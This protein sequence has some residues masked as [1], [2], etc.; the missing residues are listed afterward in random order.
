MQYVASSQ[1]LS[2]QRGDNCEVRHLRP[3]HARNAS[4]FDPERSRTKPPPSSL[5]GFLPCE[6]LLESEPLL[7][8]RRPLDEF[9]DTPPP[10]SVEVVRRLAERGLS[11]A[12]SIPTPKVSALP[13]SMVAHGQKASA[14]E[15]F[16]GDGTASPSLLLLR[17]TP[18]G[19]AAD[20]LALPVPGEPR[21]LRAP[22]PPDL[23]P[24]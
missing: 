4:H 9:R 10:L 23:M 19:D 16:Q 1:I 3:C 11:G 8:D 18:R 6:V 21:G 20:E 5:E 2:F 22:I 17:W 13:R 14:G 12:V 24:E 7:S 15:P